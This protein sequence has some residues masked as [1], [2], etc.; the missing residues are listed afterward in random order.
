MQSNSHVRW[1]LDIAP[2]G[3][4]MISSP[5]PTAVLLQTVPLASAFPSANPLLLDSV[6]LM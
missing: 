3:A 2:G 1:E 5:G 6:L 4:N